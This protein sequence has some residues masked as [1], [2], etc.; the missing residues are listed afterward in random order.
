MEYARKKLGLDFSAV[1]PLGDRG[2]RRVDKDTNELVA[3]L[4]TAAGI[5][6]EDAC[7]VAI[8]VPLPG[9]AETVL[10]DLEQATIDAHQLIL[11]ARVLARRAIR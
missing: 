6:M 1:C 7:P 4:C 9:Q 3:R 10:I 8:S 2:G 11:A 5:I